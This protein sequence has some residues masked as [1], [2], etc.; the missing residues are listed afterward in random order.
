MPGACRT[1]DRCTEEKGDANENPGSPSGP[2]S[3]QCADD[4]RDE[5]RLA[6]EPGDDPFRVCREDPRVHAKDQRNEGLGPRQS[7]EAEQSGRC[8]PSPLLCRP[9][10]G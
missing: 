6:E 8:W 5:D 4:E 3:E 1:Y 9:L 7:D 2:P 10:G